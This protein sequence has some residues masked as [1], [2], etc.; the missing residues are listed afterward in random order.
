MAE[1]GKK[2]SAKTAGKTQTLGGKFF[3]QALERLAKLENS[4]K[5]KS[6]SSLKKETSL[7]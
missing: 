6:K 1:W 3:V 7:Q 5:K 4:V 2:A